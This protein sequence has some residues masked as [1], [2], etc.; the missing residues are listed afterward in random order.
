MTASVQHQAWSELA[1]RENEG[2]TVS[3]L[4]S[5][6]TG[7]VKVAVTD[8]RLDEQ[9]EIHVAGVDALAAFHHPFAYA[10]GPGASFDDAGSQRGFHPAPERSTV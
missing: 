9:F 6:D 3:L 10:A 7:R 8:A 1:L 2:L 5:S 4:W